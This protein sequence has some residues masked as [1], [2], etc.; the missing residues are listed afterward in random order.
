[1][2]TVRI[3]GKLYLAGEYAVTHPGQPAVIIA[4]DRFLELT[5]SEATTSNGSV[6]SEGYT[7]TP[8]LISRKN[9]RPELPSS[10]ELIQQTLQLI[11]RYIRELG[12]VIRPYDLDLRT[13]LE[14]MDSLAIG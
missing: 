14:V 7:D 8:L 2:T 9:N 5:V 3:P 4:V 12:K 6:Y 1:M 13:D 10:F 11:E